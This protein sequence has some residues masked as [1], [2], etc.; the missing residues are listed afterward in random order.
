MFKESS[1]KAKEKF[2]REMHDFVWACALT[3][4]TNDL[5]SRGYLLYII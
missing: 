5:S 3:V 4:T 2:L 1:L